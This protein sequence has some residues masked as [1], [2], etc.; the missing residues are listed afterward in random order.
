MSMSSWAS[1]FSMS[2]VVVEPVTG[3]T[4]EIVT[5]IFAWPLE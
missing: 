3:T 4:S 1:I 5:F 2:F